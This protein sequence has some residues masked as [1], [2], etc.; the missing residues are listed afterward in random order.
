MTQASDP[1]RPR[2][3]KDVL[4]SRLARI[5]PLVERAT[6]EPLQRPK[7]PS[8]RKAPLNYRRSFKDWASI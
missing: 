7:T 2:E 4:R 3:S 1:P 8:P 6:G 5:A